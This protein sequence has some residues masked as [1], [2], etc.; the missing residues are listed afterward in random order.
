MPTVTLTIGRLGPVTFA[1]SRRAKRL[2]ISIKPFRPVRVAF[3]LQISLKK[4]QHYLYEHWDWVQ[5]NLDTIRHI[6]RDHASTLHDSPKAPPARA[7]ALLK[8][9]LQELAQQHGFTYNKVSVRNQRSRWGSCSHLNNI[10]LNIN[11][12][13]LTG[14]LMDYVLLH[15]LVH[16]RIKNHSKAY[17]AELDG[18]VG[19]KGKAKELDKRLSKH[20]LGTR[21]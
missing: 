17:W 12:V 13:S 10:S 11:L 4:A 7:K 20:R 5:T 3:P 9:R 21:R 8:D 6:E 18:Y 2:S 19:G 1:Q 16:T 14:D 15:E